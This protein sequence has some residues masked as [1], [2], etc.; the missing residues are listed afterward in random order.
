M[1]GDAADRSHH[2]VPH[3][4]QAKGRETLWWEQKGRVGAS[5]GLEEVMENKT[6]L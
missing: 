6:V 2:A 5:K 3:V 4:R 1:K